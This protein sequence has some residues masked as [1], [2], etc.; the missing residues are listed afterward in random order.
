MNDERAMILKMLQEGKITVDEADALLDVLNEQAAADASGFA[1]D[2]RS[3]AS[4]NEGGSSASDS[5]RDTHAG[6]GSAGGSGT[7][8]VFAERD[9]EGAGA[10]DESGV[11]VDIDLSG[12]KES[13][14]A[15]MGS[16][17]ETIRGVSETLRD[18]F[19]GLG[20]VEVHTEFGRA[21]GRER[22]DEERSLAAESGADGALRVANAW[23]DIR[24][25][26]ADVA[27]ITGSAQITAWAATEEEAEEAVRETL[28]RLARED[29]EWVL[30]SEL[31]ARTRTRID[32][33]LTVPRAFAV[34]VTGASGDLWLED[35]AGSQNVNTLSGD[36]DVAS[37]GSSTADR[38]VISTKSGDVVAAELTGETTLNSLSGEISVNGFTGF[39]RVSTQSGDVEV[40]DGHGSV[41]VQAMSGDVDVELAS[42]GER[43]IKL[44]TV[45]GDVELTVP[46]DASLA[47]NA[48][49]TS[50]DAEV[51]LELD[52]AERGKHRVAGRLNGGSLPVELSSVSGDVSV[53]EA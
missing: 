21:M 29:G 47:I 46:S 28:V 43:P 34:T 33:E 24:I 3:A 32:L 37:I 8:R 7:S 31:A 35:L 2:A 39:L 50:G 53:E 13:L 10:R 15:T 19:S 14:R 49:S 18:A 9:E 17:R 5:G 44:T 40:T 16:V 52:Q 26:G 1:A 25:T 48:H 41:E 45:S 51:E 12:L 23:G 42:V 20:D 6:S 38:H 36:I 30:S 11:K 22:A 4:G 27:R